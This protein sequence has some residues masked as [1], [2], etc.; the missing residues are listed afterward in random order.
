MTCISTIA[1]RNVGDL[2]GVSSKF[3]IQTCDY[4]SHA[5]KV[6]SW[7]GYVPKVIKLVL[8]PKKPQIVC[9]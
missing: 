3:S 5:V 9:F 1:K 6:S 8:F 2:M 4:E 7:K